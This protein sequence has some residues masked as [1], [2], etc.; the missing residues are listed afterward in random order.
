MEYSCS[1]VLFEKDGMKF[2]KIT[3]NKYSMT[4]S[5]ENKNI[6][7]S[8]IIDFGLIKL[9]YDLNP[10]VYE[11]VSFEKI[12]EDEATATL[13]MKNFFE[14]LGLPQKYAYLHIKKQFQSQNIIFNS[15]SIQSIRPKDIPDDA[16]QMAM[17]ENIGI[18]ELITPHK[19]NFSF[20]V[21]FEENVMIPVFAEKMIGVILNKIFKRVKQFIET[22]TIN[23]ND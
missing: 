21:L 3:N 10:D 7:L 14:D 4:F 16:E 15:K 6:I 20:T 17:K 13:L 5:M 12:N 18:C 1:K 22:I 19:L 8:N 9:I 11:Y 2:T 23:K